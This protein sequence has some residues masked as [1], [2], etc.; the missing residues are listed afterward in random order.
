LNA[1]A[2]DR[3]GGLDVLHDA[4][5]AP[6]PLAANAVR[7]AVRAASL[8]L[9]D[10]KVRRGEMGPLV[11]RSFPKIPGS[12]LAGLVLEVGAA[13]RDVRVG[14]A[15][16]GAVNPFLGGTLADFVDVPALQLAAKP[17]W[18]SFEDAA[19]LPIAGLAALQGLRD[20]ARVQAGQRVLIHG[21]SGGVGLFAVQIAKAMGAQV[22]GVAGAG[23]QAVGEAGADLVLDYRAGAALAGPYE[24]IFNAS[25]KL[26][27][28]Q[29]KAFLTGDGVLI[30]PAPTIPVFIGSKLANLFRR[31]RH[32]V[33]AVTPKRVDLVELTSLMGAGRLKTRI[34]TTYAFAQAREAFGQLERGGVI[35]KIVLTR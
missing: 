35:G 15:V 32:A 19:S 25:G 20:L 27:F 2:Y 10:A 34:A 9:I 5:I 24:V 3:F 33:L 6:K 14:E 11:S 17:D 4:V 30:E 7:V 28:A 1:L 31:R 22:T 26:P 29:A 21:A 18:L 12:D 23:G 16:F 8:N 13:V